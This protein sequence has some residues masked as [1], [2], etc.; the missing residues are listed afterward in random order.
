MEE[1]ILITVKEQLGY[2]DYDTYDKE[3][4]MHINTV[5]N[6]LTQMGVGP[7]EGFRI[8]GPDETWTDFMEDSIKL[9]QVK[10][11]VCLK[12]RSIFDPS[13]NNALNEARKEQIKELEFRIMV[14]SD[15]G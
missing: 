3:F 13:A 15:P 8:T 7:A 9:E 1:R 11:Y 5:L 2:A 6:A 12:V 10:D 14:E 4:V